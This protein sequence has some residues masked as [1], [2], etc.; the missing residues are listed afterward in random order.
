V[1][2]EREVS[3]I[4]GASEIKSAA[5]ASGLPCVALEL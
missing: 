3:A 5:L 4:D 1:R 2:V